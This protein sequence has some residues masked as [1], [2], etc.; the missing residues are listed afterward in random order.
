MSNTLE[1]FKLA[2]KNLLKAT[3]FIGSGV[4]ITYCILYIIKLILVQVETDPAM[5]DLKAWLIGSVGF[6]IFMIV[7][8]AVEDARLKIKLKNDYPDYYKDAQ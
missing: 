8:W 1:V 2:I 7:Y 5:I 4:L 3:T 6:V